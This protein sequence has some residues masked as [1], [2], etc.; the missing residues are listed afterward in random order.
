MDWMK[1]NDKKWTGK[2]V[3]LMIQTDALNLQNVCMEL[4][5][6]YRIALYP[7]NP[8]DLKVRGL[9]NVG[10]W[11]EQ[12]GRPDAADD[13]QGAAAL[14]DDGLQRVKDGHVPDKNNDCWI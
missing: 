3:N 5:S 14:W 2:N 11:G 9:D 1:W 6:R 12:G 7:A 13:P 8:V 4:Y 10:Y